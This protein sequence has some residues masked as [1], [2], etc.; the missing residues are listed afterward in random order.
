MDFETDMDAAKHWVNM[1][2]IEAVPNSA[3]KFVLQLKTDDI[4]VGNRGTSSV[5]G[6][7]EALAQLRNEAGLNPGQIAG[8]THHFSRVSAPEP[9]T[10]SLPSNRRDDVVG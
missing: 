1:S 2:I 10:S 7:G 4:Y 6:I 5:V 3:H 8:L 9:S